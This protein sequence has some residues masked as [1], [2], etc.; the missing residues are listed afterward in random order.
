MSAKM[1]NTITTAVP[2]AIPNPNTKLD[3]I[4]VDTKVKGLEGTPATVYMMAFNNHV[5]MG[6]SSGCAGCR[7]NLNIAAS[8]D[9]RK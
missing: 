8:T 4:R 9:G 2:A 6:E 5:K 7:T 3:M 1:S